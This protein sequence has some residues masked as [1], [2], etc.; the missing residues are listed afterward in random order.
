EDHQGSISRITDAAGASYVGESFTAFGARRDAGDWSS[1]CNCTDLAKM[2]AVTRMGYTGQEAIGGVSMGLNHMNGRVQ[3]A[4]TGRFLSPDPYISEP[5]NTQSYNRY[6]YVNNNPLSQVD[7]TGFTN[8][9]R[10]NTRPEDGTI[11]P[12]EE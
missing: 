6:S 4:I 12:A 11:S 7:P 2:K 5:G 3:D 9:D 1:A 10:P 8:K